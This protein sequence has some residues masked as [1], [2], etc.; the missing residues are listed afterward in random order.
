MAQSNHG[1]GH[2][3]PQPADCSVIQ[4]QLGAARAKNLTRQ[5][6]ND[7][8]FGELF[9]WEVIYEINQHF[10]HWFEPPV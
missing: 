7:S 4:Y 5:I 2:F 9:D 10:P 8:K 6:R 3:L 1:M